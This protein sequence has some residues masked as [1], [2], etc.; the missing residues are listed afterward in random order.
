MTDQNMNVLL[1]IANQKRKIGRMNRAE[2]IHYVESTRNLVRILAR[3][4][5]TDRAEQRSDMEI[6]LTYAENCLARML[7]RPQ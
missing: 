3:F 4:E 6:L 2:L 1:Q 5:G 7:K